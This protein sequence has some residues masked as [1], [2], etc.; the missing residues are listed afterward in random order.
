MRLEVTQQLETLG[1][2]LG[3]P[4]LRG[5]FPALVRSELAD[6]QRD[7]RQRWFHDNRI[8]TEELVWLVPGTVWAADFS[9][10][11]VPIDDGFDH[12]LGVRD[13][14]SQKR[15]LDLPG[16]EADAAAAVTAV[17]W[18][19]LQHGAPLVC[20]TDNGSPFVAQLFEQLLERWQVIPLLSPPRT[21][22]YNG[23]VEAGFGSFKTRVYYEAVRHGR[24]GAW[25]SDDL[26]AAHGLSNCAA[27]PWGA[28]GPTPQEAW[29]RRPRITPQQR[30]QFL[31]C[32]AQATAALQVQLDHGL[33]EELQVAPRASVA[34]EAVRR[35]LEELGYLL[36]RRRRVSPPFNSSL[37]AIIT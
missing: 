7:Y 32:V 12:V 9:D 29:D 34:R 27:R 22:R 14:A 19:F 33:N 4:A 5:L 3:M 13:L 23:A 20:K 25:T 26:E 35:A 21:P 18:L 17:E 15:L 28:H 24:I 31:E 11:P 37:R 36:V 6:L 1:P 8:D 2:T 16:T 10:S 30:T